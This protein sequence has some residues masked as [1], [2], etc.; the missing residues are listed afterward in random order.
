MAACQVVSLSNLCGTSVSSLSLLWTRNLET[1]YFQ[2]SR[3]Y[4]CICCCNG[5]NHN[6]FI[7]HLM[8]MLLALWNILLSFTPISEHLKSIVHEPVDPAR[9]NVGCQGRAPL[10]SVRRH[11]TFVEKS[12]AS[13]SNLMDGFFLTA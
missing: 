3:C 5:A 7:L 11:C 2:M 9:G 10:C 1:H 6:E 13:R 12:A 8:Q 4:E